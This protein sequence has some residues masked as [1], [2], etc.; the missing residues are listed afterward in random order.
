MDDVVD[1]KLKILVEVARNQPG[2]KQTNIARKFGITPQ[3]VSENIKTLKKD[4]FL[5]EGEEGYYVTMEGVQ[6]IIDQSEFLK[7]FYEDIQRNVLNKI[8]YFTAIAEVHVTEGME[9]GL[10]ME[11]GLLKAGS[12]EDSSAHGVATS[13]ADVGDEVNIKEI[14]GII[15]MAPGKVTV[16]RV[17]PKK[18]GGS[19]IGY[20]VE[21]G[22]QID[23]TAAVGLP[24]LVAMRK[25]YGEPDLFF[26]AKQAVSHAASHGLDVFVFC[27][28]T[29]LQDL[30]D[31]LEESNIDYS[32]VDS[33]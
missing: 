20:E 7:N 31:S 14:S 11:G 10:Y 16:V 15:D 17:P 27:S 1:T 33:H 28:H 8:P 25:S 21:V 29:E 12:K 18:D 5:R 30:V 26:G 23:L 3:A 24:G 4:G 32:I 9:V 13:D 22:E 2:V 19:N 6:R